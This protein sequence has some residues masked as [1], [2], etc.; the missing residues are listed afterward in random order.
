MAKHWRDKT[1][2][3]LEGSNIET[4]S[5]LLGRFLADRGE[6]ARIPDRDLFTDGNFEWGVPPLE[7]VVLTS[8]DLDQLA[9]RP[10]LYG[11]SI[12]IVEPWDNVGFHPTGVPVRASKNIAYIAQKIADCGSIL[13]PVWQLG[14]RDIRLIVEIISRSALYVIEGGNGSVNDPDGWNNEVCSLEDLLFLV[15]TLL[16][17]R[18]P[19]SAPGLFIC[20]GHQLVAECLIRLLKKACDFAFLAND[21]PNDPTGE[22]L[23][24]IKRTTDEI[25]A[26]GE[27]LKI[28]KRSGRVLA[29]GWESPGFAV[30][31]LH[32]SEVGKTYIRPYAA[33]IGSSLDREII[34]AQLRIDEE[35]ETIIDQMLRL[36]YEAAIDVPMFHSQEVSEVAML[37]ANW[38]FGKL[39]AVLSIRRDVVAVSPLSWLLRLP[40]AV[41][42]L[43][44]TES[45]GEILTECASMCVAYKDHESKQIRRNFTIQFHPELLGDLHD[46]GH[47]PAPTFGELQQADSVRLLVRLMY[48]GLYDL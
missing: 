33:P 28:S 47:R 29:E 17:R 12:C 10:Q 19:K 25:Q 8:S 43:A 46:F 27:T 42:I 16:Q 40:Y 2:Y 45:D 36:R 32:K 14:V 6:T 26:V 30:N 21:L 44:M 11:N 22:H 48:L 37:F 24:A 34:E 1:G 4:A 20:V 9:S 3:L 38:A 18:G 31:D 7:K 39:H 35:L 41:K 23:R 13:F 5:V 15:E